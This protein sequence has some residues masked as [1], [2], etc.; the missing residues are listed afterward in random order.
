VLKGIGVDAVSA[1][2][3]ADLLARSGPLFLRRILSEKELCDV[4]SNPDPVLNSAMLFAGKEAVFK[5]FGRGWE[6]GAG[7]RDIEI[8]R[9]EAGPSPVT[10]QG[11]FQEMME[12]DAASSLS[13]WL[14]SRGETAVAIAIRE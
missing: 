14:S 7:Y 8:D 12:E 1:G 4:W 9:A 13:L 11:A 6:R 5:T 10:L 2:R 3:M